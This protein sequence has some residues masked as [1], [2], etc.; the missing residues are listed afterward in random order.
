MLAAGAAS[1]LGLELVDGAET[2]ADGS[3]N[4]VGV[5][6]AVACVGR[7]VGTSRNLATE[8][9]VG[10]F[11]ETVV[12][13][14]ADL[15]G[16][17]EEVGGGGAPV[18]AVEGAE[19]VAGEGGC[20]GGLGAAAVCRDNRD[21][22]EVGRP[23]V[24]AV[25]SVDGWDTYQLSCGLTGGA[26]NI[27]TIFG[28]STTTLSAPAA[29][30]EAA[31]FGSNI[32]GVNPAFVA[33]SASAAVDSW[34]TVGMTGGNSGA[35]SS[36]GIDWDSWTA[37]SALSADNGAVFWM[38]PDDGPAGTV[39]LAQI[40]VTAG[41]TG[42]V[43]M[44]AQGRSASGG[45]WT[46]A[47]VTFNLGGGGGGGAPSIGGANCDATVTVVD[48]LD[49][50]D[51]YQLGLALTNGA[52]N[53]YTVFGDSTTTLTA[54]A[55][56]QEA[57]PFGANVGGVSPA[58]VA[59]SAS[60]GVDSW[61]SVG[62]SDGSAGGALSSIGIDWDSWTAD[63][64]LSADNGAVFWMV[65]DNGPS[66]SAIVGQI[67]IPA[68][69]SGTVTMGAQGR[70]ASGGDWTNQGITFNI[71]GGAAAPPPPSSIG[72]D[73]CD[74][75]VTVVDS[76][77]GWNTYQLGLALT[78]GASN[79]Y[80]VFGDS[81]TTLTA[82]A[83]YQEAA[84]FGANV[85]GVSPAFVAVS[86]S[87][88]VDSWLSVG[89]S[90]GSAG[91]ALSSIGID[92][93]SWTADSA[94]SADNGAVFWMVPDN[95]PSGSAIV[96]QI[97]IP[98]GTSGTVTMGAQGRSA[99]GDDWK[100]QGITFN[101][102][103]G[104]GGSAP[105]PPPSSTPVNPGDV[106]ECPTDYAFAGPAFVDISTTGTQITDWAQNPDDG[107]FEIA[108][109]FTMPWYGLTEDVIHVGTNGYITFGTEHFA[110]GNS[111]PFPGTPAG[112]VD[113]VIGVY[114]A[115]INPDPA[116]NVAGAGVFYQAFGADSMVVQ[117]HNVVYWTANA[118]P[119]TN[120]FQAT[121]FSSGGVILAYGA[122]NDATGTLSWSEESIGYESQ[123]GASGV[124]ISW[125][126][127]PESNTAYYIPPVCTFLTE[128]PAP[129]PEYLCDA[130]DMMV[131]WT[132]GFHAAGHAVFDGY[133]GTHDARTTSEAQVV[134]A[135]P[136]NGCV[137]DETGDGQASPTGLAN[138]AAMPGKIAL[139]RR[140]VCFFTTKVVNAQNAG[141][142][143]AVIYNDDRPGTVVM[144][145]PDVGITIPSV[146]IEGT[147]GDAL[148]AAVTAD[149]STIVSIHCDAESRHLNV[150]DAEDMVLD[151]T[152]GFHVSGHAVFDGYGGVHNADDTANAQI[153]IADPL[154][155]CV[156]DETGDGQA[157][158]TGLA[159][160]A[161][162]P[163]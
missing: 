130:E 28:D 52:S 149:S 112:P 154:N 26:A 30:Q 23:G 87:A 78:N 153:V 110:F 22:V 7:S 145:G 69:T 44:G 24:T 109:P 73:N 18:A 94:L 1:L 134:I 91:G 95:G 51:T 6:P 36:I 126:A 31:P 155:G 70:S 13:L 15:V 14:T 132:G 159:N 35:L 113:G 150:C 143:G 59:V 85:G 72:G 56:Y 11:V 77:D 29:Y 104:G 20:A 137:G 127:V 25:D 65:P 100:N 10:S 5:A 66:G 141:A 74:A 152:G 117:W 63:S 122:M 138:A 101:I 9:E 147:D 119:T 50:W 2:R 120:T 161:A 136:L 80:T 58:F 67:T 156:G 12:G 108:L 32:G 37:D 46:D 81:T 39:V 129:P 151:W 64:A 17:A 89:P 105:S 34:L 16:A 103:G 115:D 79:I 99:S 86:A 148:N 90:D 131:D 40:T 107:W 128:P 45:D 21:S 62:P 38:V 135:D 118:D 42:S 96:G 4:V 144:S 124:Q 142:I 61:L 82:P 75:T 19:L 54:P 162:M 41:S 106:A 3:A 125:D 160:A 33:V 47:G 84:P 49:G 97:T 98:A 92:W 76:L 111:A 157:S 57:A 146:F 93:D 158:P 53:I 43:T 163:G 102:G 71:G 48:S 114:W 8:A 68:G 116:A 133:G 139:I 121:L 27:Y 83:A 140:G 88:G 123:D 60:A 55:A